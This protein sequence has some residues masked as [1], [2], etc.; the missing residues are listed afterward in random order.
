[1]ESSAPPQPPTG[2][3]PVSAWRYRDVVLAFL[4]GVVGS[5]LVAVGVEVAGASAFDPIPF[6]LIFGGQA[7]ASF[8][9]I[10][11]LSRRRGSGSL[12]ADVGL[13]V[14]AGDWWG[15]P[16]GMGLQIAIALVTLPLLQL[17]FPDGAPEQSVAEI[18]SSSETLLDQLFVI[19]SVAVAAPIIE[20]MIFRGMLM[21]IL[22]RSFGAWVS[23]IV[24]AAVFA[25]VHL[26]DPDAI[27]AVP[28]LFLLG[29]VLGWVALRRGDLSLAIALHSG[30]NLLAAISLLWGDELLQWSERQLEQME[31]VIHLLPFW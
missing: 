2:Y 14:R 18:A 26:V 23:I 31:G 24:S 15:V 10:L 7:A 3:L 1:M 16:A 13:V 29:L 25:L 19:A 22:R 17:L 27:A 12:A 30:I 5:F 28:G 8:G 11:W 21:S 20:E 6:S 4:A 9:V